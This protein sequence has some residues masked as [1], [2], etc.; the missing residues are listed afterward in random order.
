MNGILNRIMSA[1]YGLLYIALASGIMCSLC[2]LIFSVDLYR[3]SAN[4]YAFMARAL[5]QGN[6]ADAFHE[7]IPHLNVCCSFPFSIMGMAPEKALLLVSCLFYLGATAYLFFLMRE[8]VPEKL[9]GFGAILFALAP[10]VIRFFCTALIDSGKCFFLVAALYYGYKLIRS[11]FRSWGNAVGFGVSLGLLSL[12]RS[13]AVANA[14]IL[15]ICIGI[16]SIVEAFRCKRFVPFFTPL[17]SGVIM[18]IFLISRIVLMGIFCGKWVYDG[19]IAQGVSKIFP[20]LSSTVGSAAADTVPVNVYDSSWSHLVEQNARG[21]YEVYLLF[22]V[23]GLL[24]LLLV[25][26]KKNA[27]ALFPDKKMPDFIRWNNYYWVFL[28][29]FVS[30]MLI[31]KAAK[32][33]AYRYFLLNIPVL[34]VFTLFGVYWAWRYLSGFVS[35]KFVL[36]CLAVIMLLQTVNGLSY[37]IKKQY[38]IDYNAGVYLRENLPPG[39]ALAVGKAAGVWYYSGL[40]KARP[41]EAPPVDLATFNDF[42]YIICPLKDEEIKIFEARTDLQ[43]IKIPIK[44]SVRVFEKIR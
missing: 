28:A 34:M 11:S 25:R 9:A 8:F 30:N 26:Y 16:F 36:P 5:A 3:D 10:K 31:F 24:L 20:Q 35:R 40:E 18:M 29:V 4:V 39:K 15:G 33:L 1:R 12:A 14:G 41:V 32:I 19:R 43:E 22:T 38:R 44:S 17:L 42:R 13:E 6:Y 7:N 27:P 2:Q 37:C 23:A 21:C